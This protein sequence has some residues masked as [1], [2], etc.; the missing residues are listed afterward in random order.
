LHKKQKNRRNFLQDD[1]CCH[2]RSK[3]LLFE[4]AQR[5]SPP[6]EQVIETALQAQSTREKAGVPH[7]REILRRAADVMAQQ[8]FQT[9]A[10]MRLAG[11]KAVSEGNSE[12]SEAID[13]A[14]YYVDYEAPEGVKAQ[15][16]GI[17]V[18]TPP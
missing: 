16:L 1:L 14:R 8:R 5:Y 17:V 13:F 18:V 12:V 10:C 6:L 3:P 2:F 11:K 7:R 9:L 4:S 15:A